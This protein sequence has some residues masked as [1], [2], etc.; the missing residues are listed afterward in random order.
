[1]ERIELN[2]IDYQIKHGIEMG[3]NSNSIVWISLN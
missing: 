2:W 3:Y 1:L